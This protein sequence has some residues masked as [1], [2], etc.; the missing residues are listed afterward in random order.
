MEPG[1]DRRFFL[2]ALAGA[3]PP[4]V[5]MDLKAFDA[6]AKTF[7]PTQRMPALFVGHGSPTNAVETNPYTRS[8]TALGQ[9]LPRPRAILVVSAHWL[10]NGTAVGV[11]AKPETIH[12]FYGFPDELYS[13][14]Y[15]CPGAPELAEAA[16]GLVESVPVR[17]DDRMGL[18]HGAWS[19]LKHMYPGADIPAF[20][21]SIDA[22]KPPDVHYKLG[23]ELRALRSRGVLVIGSGNLVHNLRELNWEEEEATPFDWAAEF[24][25]FVRKNVLEK[26][27][28]ALLK[29]ASLGSLARRAHPTNDHYLPLMYFL[30]LQE[31]GEEPRFTFEGFQY[32]S[33]SMRCIAVG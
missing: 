24:D 8:L 9:T 4:V 32:G 28:A 30:G 14:L 18:D 3:I 26:N 16:A 6:I 31:K 10:T 22:A 19:V 23:G 20:Q 2:N 27:H 15:P 13:I 25:D 5:M 17:K 21:L 29:Y 7:A 11:A 12:D 1:M 33:V